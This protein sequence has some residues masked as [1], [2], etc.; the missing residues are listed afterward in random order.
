MNSELCISVIVKCHNEGTKHNLI[1]IYIIKSHLKTL[2]RTEIS[3]C[4]T[5]VW[6]NLKER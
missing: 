3:C 4:R 5:T 6:T 2:L 1:H